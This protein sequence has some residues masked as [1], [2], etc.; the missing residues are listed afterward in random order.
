MNVGV[1]YFVLD[2][3]KPDTDNV[4]DAHEA[5]NSYAGTPTL[6]ISVCHCS[7]LNWAVGS[8]FLEG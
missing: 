7:A 8:S 2:N 4:V 6:F 1:P 3:D 5:V